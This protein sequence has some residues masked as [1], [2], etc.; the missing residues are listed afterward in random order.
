M[1][2]IP[3]LEELFATNSNSDKAIAMTKYQ[4]NHFLF[5]G[6]K[7]ELRKQLLKEIWNKNKQEIN[8]NSRQIAL[9]LFTKPNR[10]F[11]Y[12]AIE[13]LI[14]TLHKKYKKKDIE[15]INHLLTTNS[16]WDSVDSIAKNILGAYLLVYP[17]QRIKIVASYSNS[18]NLWLQ[19]SA[20][21][22]QLGYKKTTDST[23]L[24]SQCLYH[25]TSNEFFIKKAIGW[26][27]REYGKTNPTEVI[28]F[29]TT[30]KLKPL[31]KKEA[32]KNIG[33]AINN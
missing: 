5:F 21:I 11:H 13:I 6:I 28:S 29:V 4:K 26:A 25:A 2:F 8:E 15:L 20:I 18:E 16:W 31:S 7:A 19:R 1:S 3:D 24:F 17:D 22:F 12:C 9:E 27:L 23:I 14:K 10:E 32:L 30:T 33:K